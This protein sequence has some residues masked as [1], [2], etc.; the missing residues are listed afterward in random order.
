M[1]EPAPIRYHQVAAEAADWFVAMQSPAVTDAERAAFGQWLAQSAVH[2]HEYLE[3]TRLWQEL[4]RGDSV[5]LAAAERAALVESARRDLEVTPLRPSAAA[6]PPAAAP[7]SRR[8]A[9]AALAAGLLAVAIG[10]GALLQLQ[11]DRDHFSTA[12]GEQSTFPLADGSIVRLNTQSEIRVRYAP[13]SREIELLR[14]EALFE[15]AKDA[16]RPFRV[17]AGRTTVEAVGTVF[18]V[19]RRADQSTVTVIEGRVRVEAPPAAGGGAADIQPATV[20]TE[21]RARQQATVSAAGRLVAVGSAVPERVT[22][23]TQ[24]RLMFAGETL[25]EVADEFNRYN[26]RQIVVDGPLAELRVNAV[27]NAT[28]PGSL[29][30][31]LER[32]ERVVVRRRD[33]GSQVLSWPAAPADRPRG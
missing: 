20:A 2:V 22:A 5:A 24:R 18:E 4:G 33:D 25:A 6:P 15:V 16:A 11:H 31:F 21:V 14:G 23:W 26:P 29:I 28:D 8:T 30:E 17:H 7:R 19:Y 12:T 1:T 27:F 13:A 32:T 10:A 9:T 3:V